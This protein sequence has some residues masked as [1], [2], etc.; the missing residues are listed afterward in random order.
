MAAT[1]WVAEVSLALLRTLRSWGTASVRR[2]SMT[3]MTMSSS[4]RVKP[5]SC[6]WLS[7]WS[8]MAF[9]MVVMF[10]RRSFLVRVGEYAAIFSF[11]LYQSRAF[12][13]RYQMLDEP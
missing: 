13:A 10:P 2:M 6:C 3:D 8:L 4:M 11:K 7:R 1:D 9:L 12:E 5:A